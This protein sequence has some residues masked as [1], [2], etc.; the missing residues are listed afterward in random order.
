[1]VEGEAEQ[2]KG[3]AEASDSWSLCRRKYKLMV[4]QFN[5]PCLLIIFPLIQAVAMLDLSGII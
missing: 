1:M 5:D 2:L 3:D 4:V